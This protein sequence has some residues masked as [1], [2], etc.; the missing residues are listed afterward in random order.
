MEHSVHSQESDALLNSPTIALLTHVRT[1][2]V[3]TID[4]CTRGKD[5]S[6]VLSPVK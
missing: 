4:Q 2:H 5:G 6:G 3:C 1:V